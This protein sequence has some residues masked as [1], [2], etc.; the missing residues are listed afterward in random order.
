MVDLIFAHHFTFD[1]TIHLKDVICDHLS[2]YVK[3]YSVH[4]VR[5]CPKAPLIGAFAINYCEVRTTH[6]NV[7][8]AI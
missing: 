2:M 5:L 6:R 8:Y 7:L 3:L 1:M 4:D